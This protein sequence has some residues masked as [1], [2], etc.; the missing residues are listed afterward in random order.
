MKTKLSILFF[1]FIVLSSESIFAQKTSIRQEI[2]QHGAEIRKAFQEENIEQIKRLHHPNVI[3]ALGYN[4][5]KNGREEVM[6]ALKETLDLY[7]LEFI[8][9]EVENFYIQDDLVI[10]QTRFSIKGT[11]KKGGESFVFQG[12]TMVTYIRYTKSPTGWATIR[13]IIQPFSE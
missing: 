9:N 10:E 7:R 5:I 6:K 13:E 1:L 2:L 8:E 3:K 11:P 4:D 12:R